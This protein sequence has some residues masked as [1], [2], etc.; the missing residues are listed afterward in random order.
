MQRLLSCHMS[1]VLPAGFSGSTLCVLVHLPFCR[2]V[3]PYFMP[4][5]IDA[6]F[7]VG[8]LL[9]TMLLICPL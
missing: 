8:F 6:L 5:P 1:A 7:L 9:C 3:Y 4:Y 2:L